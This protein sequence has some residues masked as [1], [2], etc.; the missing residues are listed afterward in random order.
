MS[1]GSKTRRILPF[2]LLAV[3]LITAIG[4]SQ[5]DSLL[6]N[7]AQA[8]VAQPT[9]PAQVGVATGGHLQYESLAEQA[10]YLDGLKTL[11]VTWVRF[12]F[13]WADIQPRSGAAYEWT[14][15]DSLVKAASQRGLRI[16]G[17]IAYAP[18]WARD[19]SCPSDKMCRP[20]EV[21]QF[22]AFSGVLASHYSTR[23]VHDWEIWNE[24]NLRIFFHPEP[25]ARYYTQLLLAAHSAIHR[26]DARAYVVSGGVSPAAVEEGD[27]PPIDF[28]TSIYAA[29]G[30][31]GFDALGAHPY[32]YNGTYDCPRQAASW[33]A[34]SQM[35]T[36][37]VSLRSIMTKYGDAG[38][39]VWATEFGA[40]TNGRGAVTEAH[41]AVMMEQALTLFR[42]SSWAGPIFLY[43]YQ[44]NGT[45]V[46]DREDWFGLIRADGTRKPAYSAVAAWIS[47]RSNPS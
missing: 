25:D 39:Q 42:G 17:M 18:S 4:L 24:P 43:S 2:S 21:A 12:D 23:G 26:A 10:A 22:A 20:R 41:Q 11:G 46:T 5:H 16:L 31:T 7:D 3:V 33:S 14:R 36:T 34:W 19:Q 32:C 1:H 37:P 38:K 13:T 15:Y 28:L 8:Q 47:G 44:D 27:V 45:D 6:R 9:A 30:R 29:G 40:P 35:A